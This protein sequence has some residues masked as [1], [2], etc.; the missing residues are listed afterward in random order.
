MRSA[1]IASLLMIL[2]WPVQDERM[3]LRPP[4][5]LSRAFAFTAGS[6][7]SFGPIVP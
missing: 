4:D 1:F 2:P 7:S 3:I 6:A 5:A